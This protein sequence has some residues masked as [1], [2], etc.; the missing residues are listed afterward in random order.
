[1]ERFTLRMEG[2][3]QLC[4]PKKINTHNPAMELKHCWRLFLTTLVNL[5]VAYLRFLGS[6]LA[7]KT[8]VPFSF[9]NT[10][11]GKT[12]VLVPIA[13]RCNDLER[14]NKA[15]EGGYHQVEVDIM[16]PN[17]LETFILKHDWPSKDHAFSLKDSRG[18]ER[19]TLKDLFEWI[20]TTRMTHKNLKVYL[21][22]KSKGAE[23]KTYARLLLE[24]LHTCKVRS[25]LIIT[26]FDHL[27]LRHLHRHRPCMTY[28]AIIEA[29]LIGLHTY[30][31]TKLPFIKVAIV[32]EIILSNSV[33]RAVKPL[34]VYV[35]TLNC[36]SSIEALKT[37]RV[38]GYFTDR[39]SS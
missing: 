16:W 36:L 25:N 8:L 5:E 27:L 24:A 9:K 26:S 10:C 4:F 34:P 20:E 22:L 2:W 12:M 1:M 39:Y 35:Y 15:I 23:R 30:L 3:K 6:L 7:S 21:D 32:S 18:I 28:G 19:L 17:P 14:L 29:S 33:L 38:S 37:T 11:I 13:H 31:K